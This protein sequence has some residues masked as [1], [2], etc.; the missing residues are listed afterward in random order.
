V[1]LFVVCQQS[2]NQGRIIIFQFFS[3]ALGFHVRQGQACKVVFSP[4]K[5]RVEHGPELERSRVFRLIRVD[6]SFEN[7]LQIVFLLATLK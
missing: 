5:D 2:P 6:W 4:F 3:G 7:L 1:N